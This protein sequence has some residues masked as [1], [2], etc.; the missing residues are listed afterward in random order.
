MQMLMIK[1]LSF[2]GELVR[3]DKNGTVITD[4]AWKNATDKSTFDGWYWYD[5]E[6]E[7]KYGNAPEWVVK[8]IAPIIEI[9]NSL[10]IPVIILLGTAGMIYVIVLGVQYTKAETADKRD[11]AKKRLINA[12][13]GV[14]IMLVALILVKIFVANAASIFGWVKETSGTET[15]TT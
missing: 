15:P 8:I 4:E 11:E 2:L 3:H 14:I 6:S 10:L 9:L 12:A 7:I 1:I 5:T 13:I